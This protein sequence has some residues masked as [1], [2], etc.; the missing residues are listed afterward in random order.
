MLAGRTVSSTHIIATFRNC[1]VLNYA[2]DRSN[3]EGSG[4]GRKPFKYL[5]AGD[6]GRIDV[7]CWNLKSSLGNTARQALSNG[8]NVGAAHDWLP[9]IS[10]PHVAFF[11]FFPI[12]SHSSQ[13]QQCVHVTPR[14]SLRVH[15]V[16]IL[17]RLRAE[18][19]W[20]NR[21]VATAVKCPHRESRGSSPF[22]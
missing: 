3:G 6:K 2:G 11:L 4:K 1:L 22:V 19:R 17:L 10:S 15:G 8:L 18:P 20:R 16:L 9:S 13:P 14:L 21:L 5:L 7:D 12:T